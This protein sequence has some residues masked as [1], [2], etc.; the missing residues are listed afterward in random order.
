LQASDD[1]AFSPTSPSASYF[2]VDLF[3]D[4]SDRALG[5]S[6]F[7]GSD[8]I[9][10]PSTVIIENLTPDGLAASDGRLRAGTKQPSLMHIIHNY[11]FHTTLLLLFFYPRYMCS[12]ESLKIEICNTGYKSYPCSHI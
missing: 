4:S 9:N 5:I 7:G 8:T 10:S 12:P 3:R 6:I 11:A 2:T 1:A